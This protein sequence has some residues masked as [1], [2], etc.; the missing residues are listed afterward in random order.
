MQLMSCMQVSYFILNA[1]EPQL[2]NRQNWDTVPEFIVQLFHN[3]Y[4]STRYIGYYTYGLVYSVLSR[5][6]HCHT[7]VMRSFE[8][9][10]ETPKA[11]PKRGGQPHKL[12]PLL[13]VSC[14]KQLKMVQLTTGQDRYNRYSPVPN[15][16]TIHQST[17]HVLSVYRDHSMQGEGKKEIFFPH[18]KLGT[19]S[20]V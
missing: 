19:D 17:P 5:R 15:R 11:N 4:V 20:G 18:T 16:Y 9:R 12:Y 8:I 7:S 13:I 2:Y 1:R 14:L 3:L 6:F 10:R